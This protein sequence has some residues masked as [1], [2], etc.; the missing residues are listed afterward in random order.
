M[1][2]KAGEVKEDAVDEKVDLA[3]A[4]VLLVAKAVG[5]DPGKVEVVEFVDV[6]K[7]R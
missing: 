3:I 1:E 4:G 2:A 5:G 6:G 7:K